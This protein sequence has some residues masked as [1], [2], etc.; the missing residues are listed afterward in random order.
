MGI[1]GLIDAPD[2]VLQAFVFSQFRQSA[3]TLRVLT[4]AGRRVI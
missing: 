2:S 1:N 3:R 4:L